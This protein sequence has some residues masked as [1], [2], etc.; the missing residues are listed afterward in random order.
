MRDDLHP[1]LLAIVMLNLAF[2]QMTDAVDS[3]WLTGLWIATATA[4]LC[5]RWRK[6]LWYR[7]TWNA[8]VV[9]TFSFLLQHAFSTGLLHMLEDGLLLAVLCQVHLMNNIGPKQKPDLLFFNSFL[10]AFVTSF[11]G[12]DMAWSICLIIY[13]AILVPAL[14]IYVTL[15][16]LPVPQEGSLRAV[17]RDSLARAFLAITV[18]GVVFAVWPRNFQHH[19]W[20]DETLRMATQDMV[21][22]SEDIQ[23]D[24][25]TTP[26]LSDTPV[27]RI[28]PSDGRADSVPAHWRGVTFVQFDGGGW[29]SYDEK[30]FGSRIASDVLWQAV[31]RTEWRRP[32]EPREPT[33]ELRLLDASGG[34]LFLPQQAAALTIRNAA[35]P[36]VLSPKGDGIIAFANATDLPPEVCVGIRLG[37]FAPA[38]RP[39]PSLSQFAPL[40]M[41][42]DPLPKALLDIAADLKHKLAPNAS[43]R[44]IAAVC[45]T[46][47]ERHRQYALP[48]TNGAARN[49]SEFLIG[50]G[51]G[52]CEYF[53]TVLALLLRLNGIPC[54]VVG[55]YLAHEWDDV[56]GE[57][58]ARQRDAHAWVEMLGNDGSWLTLDATPATAM[59]AANGPQSFFGGM[60]QSLGEAW[61]SVTAFDEKER[62]RILTWL[63]EMLRALVSR[64]WFIIAVAIAALSIIAR[65]RHAM[66]HV[67]RELGAAMHS[68]GV[69]TNTGETPREMLQRTAT[70]PIAQQSRIRLARAV[71]AHELARYGKSTSTSPPKISANSR[72]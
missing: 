27:L 8:A 58:V 38:F 65:R 72:R 23:L 21:A 5:V 54:R 67:I 1:W 11:F 15:D 60:Q 59:S 12:H 20:L 6:H 48:G 36:L 46:W 3:T 13:A 71:A 55:G 22:F 37:S 28:K 40:R 69:K 44:E 61:R 25:T 45:R 2:V 51:G 32:G 31:S 41:V 7:V 29:S 19:G 57:M 43:E 49:L 62:A 39:K 18:T 66:P 4:P 34:K 42:P 16:N 56:A 50:T 35:A 52:H 64:P 30:S 53:A 70:L 17:L 26:S 10:I 68:A 47:L 9:G 24:H 33:L 63:F 14:Q